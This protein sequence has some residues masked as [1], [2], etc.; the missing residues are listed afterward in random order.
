MP[1]AT[2]VSAPHHNGVRRWVFDED[3]FYVVYIAAIVAA[4]VVVGLWHPWT[5]SSVLQQARTAQTALRSADAAL[6]T[7][8]SRTAG[9]AASET[10]APARCDSA[11][12]DAVQA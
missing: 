5:G 11:F 6:M 12:A 10:P 3:H 4:V 2:P 7:C 1:R 8:L 9:S